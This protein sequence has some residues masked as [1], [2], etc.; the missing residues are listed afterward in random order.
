MP[1]KRLPTLAAETVVLD[2]APNQT[3]VSERLNAK[4]SATV[5]HGVSSHSG[6]EVKQRG[7]DPRR[8]LMIGLAFLATLINYLDRQTL[9]VAAPMLR[10]QFGMSNVD[11]SRVV[12]AFMLALVSL[13]MVGHTGTSAKLLAMPADNFPKSSIV[14]VYGLASMG[15]GFGGMVFSLL[16]G[17]LVDHY[18]Y[19]PVFVGYD[20]CR[21]ARLRAMRLTEFWERAERGWTWRENKRP[22]PQIAS[23]PP[24]S[25]SGGSRRGEP[26]CPNG[27]AIHPRHSNCKATDEVRPSRWRIHFDAP[28]RWCR[29]NSSVGPLPVERNSDV[30]HP[31]SRYRL[32]VAHAFRWQ[33][34]VAG[35]G[36]ASECGR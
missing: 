11:Y 8:W 7:E 27:M 29:V 6:G 2:S 13:A 9:A 15:S 19:V 21:F 18:S 10:E 36:S 23:I 3:L 35:S 4:D 24:E 30:S 34:L 28:C 12:F 33:R 22:L 32:L 31:I 16:T 17:W 1:F 25:R 26:I 5:S 20:D 14:S